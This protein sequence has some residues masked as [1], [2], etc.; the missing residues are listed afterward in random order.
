MFGDKIFFS[1]LL[2]TSTSKD[3]V[4]TQHFPAKTDV[5]NISQD[6]RQQRLVWE[7]IPSESK[8]H[9]ARKYLCPIHLHYPVLIAERSVAYSLPFCMIIKS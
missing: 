9:P 3:L 8:S 7:K 5:K 4:M 2:K 1:V 6:S